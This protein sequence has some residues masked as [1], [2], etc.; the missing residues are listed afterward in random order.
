MITEA[1]GAAIKGADVEMAAVAVQPTDSD[2]V[3]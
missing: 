2:R 3:A 1:G